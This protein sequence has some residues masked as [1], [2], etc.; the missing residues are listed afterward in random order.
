MPRFSSG[1]TGPALVALA[2][3]LV[4]LSL[5]LPRAAAALPAL[6]VTPP[7]GW[8][9]KAD[10]PQLTLLPPPKSA[11][12]QAMIF[13]QPF[14]IAPDVPALQLLAAAAFPEGKS[15]EKVTGRRTELDGY[16]AVEVWGTAVAAKAPCS[17]AAWFVW[18]GTRMIHVVV[19]ATGND[20]APAR[21]IGATLARGAKLR[22]TATF[23]PVPGAPPGVI[24]PAAW[25]P[26]NP[27]T[28]H[29][30]ARVV[31]DDPPPPPPGTIRYEILPAGYNQPVEEVLKGIDALARSVGGQVTRTD[32]LE[33]RVEGRRAIV[34]QQLLEPPRALFLGAIIFFPDTIV[35]VTYFDRRERAS[36]RRAM[37]DQLIARVAR[38]GVKA[39][40][41]PG[42]ASRNAAANTHSLRVP[43]K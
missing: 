30:L 23:L 33:T 18:K 16:A 36:G 4:L 40:P 38:A 15:N 29:F 10:E 1:F 34:F 25:R 39:K 7:P 22:E 31:A 28:A 43:A 41:P 37:V 8:R 14:L 5:A 12:V 3:A 26:S 9:I 32:G 17:L 24:A 21:K 42:K 35:R 13:D 2:A 20:P 6:E 11:F 27:D 19:L